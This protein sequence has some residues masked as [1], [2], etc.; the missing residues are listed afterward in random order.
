[1]DVSTSAVADGVA[2]SLTGSCSVLMVIKI[3]GSLHH[4]S[5]LILYVPYLDCRNGGQGAEYFNH[6]D[7]F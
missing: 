3:C 5:S 7:E 6:V 2:D 4:F 1:M